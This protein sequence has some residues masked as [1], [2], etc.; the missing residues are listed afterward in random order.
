MLIIEP[1]NGRELTQWADINWS[2]VEANVRRLQG[3]IYRAAAKGE[4]TQ[5]KTLQKL[6]VRSLS[7]K[8]KAIRQVTQENRGRHTPGIDG[9]VCDTPTARLALLSSMVPSGIPS[10]TGVQRSRGAS[11]MTS[12]CRV[13][14]L[15]G[16]GTAM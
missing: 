3:R 2:A 13:R 16:G 10:A 1:T 9:V 8:L 12:N 15:G 14:F 5:V 11:R 7:A 6:L 4:A